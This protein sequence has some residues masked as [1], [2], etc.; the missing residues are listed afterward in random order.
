MEEASGKNSRMALKCTMN[1]MSTMI[2]YIHG[3]ATE[4]RP[5]I[6]MTR[7]TIRSGRWK[8]SKRANGKKVNVK[9][10]ALAN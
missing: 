10:C 4:E 8:R 5:S 1:I 3:T 7:N 9:T 6:L 2:W